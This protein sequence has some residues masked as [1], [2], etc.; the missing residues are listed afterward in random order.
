MNLKW[1]EKFKN[2]FDFTY[3][4]VKGKIS[5]ILFPCYGGKFYWFLIFRHFKKQ[6]FYLTNDSII[7][8]ATGA[9][10]TEISLKDITN[11]QVKRGRLAKHS[12]HIHLYADK[13]YHLLINDIKDFSTDLTG[14]GHENV[15]SF[16]TTLKSSVIL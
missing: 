8:T 11:L 3:K 9:H 5:D 6:Y 4:L 1:Q 16:I 7:F 10:I 13:K 12:Y 2:T 14:N 15:N